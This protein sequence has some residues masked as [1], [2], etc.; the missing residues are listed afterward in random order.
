MYVCLWYVGA[1]CMTSDLAALH[2]WYAIAAWGFIVFLSF[3]GPPPDF[4]SGVSSGFPNFDLPFE[5][6]P[7]IMNESSLSSPAQ[8][9]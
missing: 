9:E 3:A 5:P 7:P 1:K 8:G 2:V 4:S 6:V